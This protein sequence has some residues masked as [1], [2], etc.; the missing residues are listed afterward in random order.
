[1]PNYLKNPSQPDGDLFV[2]V[3]S[4]TK[5]DPFCVLLVLES[6]WCIKAPA[7]LGWCVGKHRR[8]LS[9]HFKKHRWK[10][11]IVEVDDEDW[12]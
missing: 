7:P 11:S 5:T 2:R 8:E 4:E 12:I 6:D 9:A 1:M 10:A 3:R